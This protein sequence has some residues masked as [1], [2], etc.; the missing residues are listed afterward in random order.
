MNE[1][2]LKALLQQDQSLRDA[3]RQEPTSTPG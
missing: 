3:I 2:K 1:D